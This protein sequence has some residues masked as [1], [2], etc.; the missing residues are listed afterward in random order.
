MFSGRR[1]AY[2][3]CGVLEVNTGQFSIAP[4]LRGEVIY[5]TGKS[6]T[7]ACKLKRR[8]SLSDCWFKAFGSGVEV[9]NSIAAELHDL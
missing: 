5:Q 1:M 6:G 7:P 2:E 3:I 9:R 8:A 4:G